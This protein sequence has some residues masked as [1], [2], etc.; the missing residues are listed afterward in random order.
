MLNG[1]GQVLLREVEQI[2]DA[3][4]RATALAVVDGT[5]HLYDSL[6]L[7]HVLRLALVTHDGQFSLYHQPVDS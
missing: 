1:E 5:D 7:M 3:V 2:E 4:F 6:A